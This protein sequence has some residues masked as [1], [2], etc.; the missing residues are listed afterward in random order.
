[1]GC[2]QNR[3]GGD[4]NRF[5][6]VTMLVAETSKKRQAKTGVILEMQNLLDVLPWL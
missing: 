6:G 1:M 2:M 5:E 4:D 3:Q